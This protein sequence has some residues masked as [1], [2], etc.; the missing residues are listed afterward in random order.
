MWELI[1]SDSSQWLP[2]FINIKITYKAEYYIND[3]DS[4]LKA[5][6][7]IIDVDDMSGEDFDFTQYIGEF[8]I[9][10][11]SYLKKGNLYITIPFFKNS[12]VK[13]EDF[14]VKMVE[15]DEIFSLSNEKRLLPFHQKYMEYYGVKENSRQELIDVIPN[16]L[17]Y[18]NTGVQQYIKENM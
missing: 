15:C 14:T 10:Y 16:L 9:A 18:V 13:L 3:A 7:E 11:M 1:H 2:V 8:M 12:S 6:I 5:K 17:D 4:A